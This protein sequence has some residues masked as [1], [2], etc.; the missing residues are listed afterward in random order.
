[1]IAR[2][3]LYYLKKAGLRRGC[4]AMFLHAS[5]KLD[6]GIGALSIETL[7]RYDFRGSD[8][9]SNLRMCENWLGMR[10]RDFSSV[11]WFIPDFENVYGGG[12]HT[13]FR[14]AEYLSRK[15]IVNR[16]IV[17][18]AASVDSDKREKAI[19]AAFPSMKGIDVIAGSTNRSVPYADVSMATAWNTAYHLL[20][21]NNTQGKYYFIQDFE[22]MFYAAGSAYAMAEATYRFGF[23][24][25]TCGLWLRDLYVRLYGQIAQDFTP[26]AEE[27]LF[28]PAPDFPREKPGRVF[29]Y[30][31]PT[32]DRRAF[33]LGIMALTRLAKKYPS[34]EVVLAGWEGRYRTPFR[35][36]LLGNM[37][38]E[39]SAALYRQCDIGL[40]FSMTNLSLLP[41]QLMASGC[42]TISNHGP[43]VEW[44]LKHRDNCILTY[45]SPSSVVESFEEVI[46]DFELRRSILR[47]GLET[48]RS[49]TW[50]QEF[51][52]ICD[53]IVKGPNENGTNG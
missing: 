51:E 47:R 44:I 48:A 39:E 35:A 25:I 9:E 10:D 46:D 12:H 45:P 49:T 43:S 28:W 16:F 53:F 8:L 14:F 5:R 7:S 3:G 11:N 18:D 22:P 29:F 21:F 15:G 6:P 52:K 36:R 17:V 50:D 40:C 20:H 19:G 1:M 30:A 37:T 33:E 2:E 42:L 23:P 4:A 41:L 27:T 31:R 34:L 38:L 13:V 26:C 24:A 32:T